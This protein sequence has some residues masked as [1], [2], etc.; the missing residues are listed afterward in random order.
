MERIRAT[1]LDG[2]LQKMLQQAGAK[3]GVIHSVFERTVNILWD[4][5]LF[6]VAVCT[7][8]DA[9]ATMVIERDSLR[10]LN[11][12]SGERAWVAEG[13]LQLG[14]W[15]IDWQGA[16]GWD[17][18]VPAY[19]PG[20]S[21]LRENL[22]LALQLVQKSGKANWLQESGAK[23]SGFEEALQTML[24][25][26]TESLFRQLRRKAPSAFLKEAE[27]LLGLGNG[28]TPSGDDV[29][30]GMLAALMMPDAPIS[31]AG[32]RSKGLMELAQERTNLISY[33]TLCHAAE[34]RVRDSFLH[35]LDALLFSS[36]AAVRRR[37]ET[38]LA[39]GSSSGSEI[40]WGLLRT[41]ECFLE[42]EELPNKAEEIGEGYH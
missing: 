8:D 4:D 35:L 2:Q 28:L 19:L 13:N 42:L 11:V 40:A 16:P 7:V 17:R 30:T 15:W 22:P 9:P 31:L 39:I 21:R 34:G 32:E 38:V 14:N 23:L 1:S 37:L 25:E 33:T 5:D 12:R 26:R 20:S 27:G 36:E 29:L 24:Q 41:L 6:T 18:R 3:P 10:G